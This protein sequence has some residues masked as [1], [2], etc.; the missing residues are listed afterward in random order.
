MIDTPRDLARPLPLL[1]PQAIRDMR[2]LAGLS[3][4]PP[5]RRLGVNVATLSEWESGETVPTRQHVY[6]LLDE[7]MA[8]QREADAIRSQARRLRQRAMVEEGTSDRATPAAYAC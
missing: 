8:A 7:L 5:A 3:V 4:R 2:R 6:E 1:L